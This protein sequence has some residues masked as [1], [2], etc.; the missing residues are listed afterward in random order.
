MKNESKDFLMDIA[1]GNNLQTIQN[2]DDK[3][4]DIIKE[5]YEYLAPYINSLYYIEANILYL[6]YVHKVPQTVIADI[7]QMTQYGVSKR[8][9]SA[10]KRLSI[11][12]STPNQDVADSFEFLKN[13]ISN[14]EAMAITLFYSHKTIHTVSRVLRASNL[15]ITQTLKRN[16]NMLRTLR[17]TAD[18][19]EFKKLILER[20]LLIEINEEFMDM[21]S[22]STGYF[23]V[24]RHTIDLHIKYL[25]SLKEYNS[26]GSHS[27][28][29]GWH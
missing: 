28:R 11:F 1:G 24:V 7:F 14:N 16:L 9:V 23:L 25:E 27:F 21:I 8:I 19:V 5:N 13:I 29:K 12:M 18:V 4:K 15:S 20:K 22:N 6:N 2:E 26:R 3:L 10:L 17:D